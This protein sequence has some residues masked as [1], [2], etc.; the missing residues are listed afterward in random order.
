M[1][2][3]KQARQEHSEPNGEKLE[4]K[5]EGKLLRGDS[6]DYTNPCRKWY[7]VAFQMNA[8]TRRVNQSE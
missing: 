6:P 3:T 8:A 5:G 7:H 1:T 4:D 2:K